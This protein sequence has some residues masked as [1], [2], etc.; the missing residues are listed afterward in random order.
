MALYLKLYAYGNTLSQDMQQLYTKCKTKHG[1]HAKFFT[2]FAFGGI[3]QGTTSARDTGFCMRILV[4][5]PKNCKRNDY[6]RGDDPKI[7][8]LHPTEDRPICI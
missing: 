8:T 3:N 5:I 7:L 1:D 6:K 4:H 2:T